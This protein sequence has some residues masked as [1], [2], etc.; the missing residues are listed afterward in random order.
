MHDAQG[1]VTYPDRC[2]AMLIILSLFIKCNLV[3]K[4]DLCHSFFLRLQLID[5]VCL[6]IITYVSKQ[7]FTGLNLFK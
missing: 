3:H 2:H 7:H 5:N 6:L 4:D 1:P